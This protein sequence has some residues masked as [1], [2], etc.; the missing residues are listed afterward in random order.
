LTQGCRIIQSGEWMESRGVRKD[1][2]IATKTGMGGAPGS[3]AAPVVAAA[4]EAS[5]ERLQSDYVDLYY[6]HR[7]D[8]VMS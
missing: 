8:L 5:L 1:M 4:L 2:R 6:V 7:D 3:L